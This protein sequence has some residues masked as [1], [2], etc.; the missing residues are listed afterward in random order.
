MAKLEKRR[1]STRLAAKEPAN[2]QTVEAKAIRSKK[3]KEK[4]SRCP[5]KLRQ[6][7]TEHNLLDGCVPSTSTIQDLAT[8]CQLE[9]CHVRELNLVL[10]PLP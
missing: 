9:D 1:Q 5:V 10:D 8:M 7:I 3:L 4:L 6:F 2:F